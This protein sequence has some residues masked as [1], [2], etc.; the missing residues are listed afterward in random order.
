MPISRETQP[1]EGATPSEG[2]S[3][4]HALPPAFGF[5]LTRVPTRVGPHAL[6]A[7]RK[8]RSNGEGA[9]QNS[10]HEDIRSIRDMSCTKVNNRTM[11]EMRS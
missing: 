10:G 6:A 9:Q 3:S 1:A 11:L 5:A 8:L 7:P 2:A 4:A